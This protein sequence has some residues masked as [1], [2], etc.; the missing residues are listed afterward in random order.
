MEDLSPVKFVMIIGLLTFALV[1]A[2]CGSSSS[3]GEASNAASRGVITGFGSVYLNGIKYETGSADIVVDDD[4]NVDES[5]LRVGMIVTVKGS[6]D[7]GH[8]SGTASSIVYENELKG[9]ISNI[10]PDPVDPTQKTLIVLAQQVRVNADTR[11]EGGLSF[12]TLAIGDVVEVNGYTTDTGITATFIELQIDA[13]LIEIRGTISQLTT[14]SFEINGFNIAY[15]GTTALEDISVLV[16]GL[17]VEVKGVL[18]GAGTTLIAHEIEA[19]DQGLG[20]N[21]DD[22]EIEGIITDY[23]PIDKRFVIQGQA[24]D[25]SGAKLYP[26]SLVLADGLAVEAEGQIVA[27]VLIA[28]EIEQRGN[29]IKISAALSAVNKIDLNSGTVSF[30]FNGT[31]IV[32]RVNQQTDMEDKINNTDLTIA[33]LSAGNFVQIE[34]YSDDSGTINAIDLDLEIAGEIRIEG[35]VDSYDPVAE[36]V[37]LFG[38]NFDLS[39]AGYEDENS[40]GI[41]AGAF[42]TALEIG[43]FVELRDLDSNGIIDKAALED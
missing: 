11:Y 31:D 35:P 10:I 4:E 42:Y 23:N 27:G 9:P 6:I 24:I 2:G 8:T 29:K 34:A 16:D 20:D 14:T 38:I 32:V 13:S 7:P 17:F 40:A 3:S 15:D 30:N 5:D 41:T 37:V 26:A 21:F 36:S 19:E 25:A 12:D 22:A 28:G 18:D 1:L 39:S 43:E 33:G